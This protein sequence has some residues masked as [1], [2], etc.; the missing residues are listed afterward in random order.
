MKIIVFNKD[1]Q[2]TPFPSFDY[3][4]VMVTDDYY[5]FKGFAQTNGVFNPDIEKGEVKS[6][7]EDNAALIRD[8]IARGIWV[9]IP[10]PK[11]VSD[12]ILGSFV[13]D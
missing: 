2:P 9:V 6:S 8:N 12:V 11:W 7:W 4:Y 10:P 13:I 3:E 1:N 5:K